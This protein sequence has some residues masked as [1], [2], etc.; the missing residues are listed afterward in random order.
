MGIEASSTDAS[1]STG[2]EFNFGVLPPSVAMDDTV[3]PMD[4]EGSRTLSGVF[5][6][7]AEK[8]ICYLEQISA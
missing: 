8:N 1:V 7:V 6:E 2:G 4:L 3:A 5:A